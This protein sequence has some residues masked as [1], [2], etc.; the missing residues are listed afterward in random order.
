MIKDLNIPKTNVLNKESKS[1]AKI[2]ALPKEVHEFA[3]VQREYNSHIPYV[4][5][6]TKK[7]VIFF[8]LKKGV[9][10]VETCL[11]EDVELEENPKSI[12]IDVPAEDYIEVDIIQASNKFKSSFALTSKK[13]YEILINHGYNTVKKTQQYESV[14]DSTG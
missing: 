11:F 10:E 4:D 2:I 7:C 1:I 3:E 6:P 13:T 5:R 12:Q 9:E 14:T 8:L